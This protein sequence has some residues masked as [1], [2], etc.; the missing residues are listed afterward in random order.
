MKLPNGIVFT[1]TVTSQGITE[2]Y[3]V[4]VVAVL[5]LINQKGLNKQCM[6][7]VKLL[8]KQAWTLAV[9][10][11]SIGPKGSNSK[12]G[13]AACKIRARIKCNI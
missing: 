8:E 9:L 2:E 3:L 11:K 13:P 6:N 10:H 5:C 1:M 4:H 7:L 12:E